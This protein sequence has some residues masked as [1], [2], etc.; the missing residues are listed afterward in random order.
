MSNSSFQDDELADLA[1]PSGNG[2]LA[3]QAPFN[4]A[5]ASSLDGLVHGAERPGYSCRG[6][7]GPVDVDTW[8]QFMLRHGIRRVVV[9][10]D[11][12]Q[13]DFYQSS[14]LDAYRLPF[15][16]VT[17]VPIADF[18]VPSSDALE[19]ILDALHKAERAGHK[20]VVHCS[21]GMGRTGIALAA[22]LHVRHNLTARDAIDQTIAHARHHGAC[23]APLEAG[24]QV[25]PAL[26]CL[27]LSTKDRAS[28]P[29]A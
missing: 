2:D 21:A 22:W 5:T 19:R 3:D 14:L 24:D 6:P 13:L 29:N 11:T 9:L 20:V 18:S 7:I 28:V 23:R 26:E 4:F 8:I 12:D 15:D 27:G 25:I 16:E 17:H 1:F 10:L